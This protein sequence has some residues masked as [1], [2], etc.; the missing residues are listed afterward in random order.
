MGRGT[1]KVLFTHAQ[2]QPGIGSGKI[3]GFAGKRAQR[4]AAVVASAG[5]VS[6]AAIIPATAASAAPTPPAPGISPS[7]AET[8]TG[9]ANLF[10]T[11]TDGTV[12]TSTINGTPGTATQINTGKVA[13]APAAI[14]AGSSLI[15]F[16]VGNGGAMFTAS[17]TNG[18]WSGWTSLGGVLNASPGAAFEG[19]NAA[20]YAV[21]GRG[22]DG[23]VW[24]RDHTSAGWGSWHS[25]GG[26]LLAGTGPAAA[27]NS[28][29]YLLVVGTNKQLYVAKAGLT[30]FSGVG[31]LSTATP[32][33]ASIPGAV[34]GFVRGTNNVAYYHKF[35]ATTPGWH[36]M[37]GLFSSGLGAAAAGTGTYTVGQGTNGQVYRAT[38]SWSTY[39]PKL[40]GWV[41]V[42]G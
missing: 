34:V 6:L 10:Y 14:V 23:A 20:D 42:T 40:S 2:K 32:G 30:G 28:G 38:G 41:H 7:V 18:K 39:P 36:A 12:W 5:V 35:L 21:F 22:S 26:K 29:V 11:A 31:G 15:V 17:K 3:T 13:S 37:G 8:S 33:L 19:P 25:D 1:S 4:L 24:A 16:A 27:A 9:V